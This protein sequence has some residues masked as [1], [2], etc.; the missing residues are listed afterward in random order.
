MPGTMVSRPRTQ[1]HAITGADSDPGERP[2]E[3]DQQALVEHRAPHLPARRAERAQDADLARAL[4]HRHRQRV[5]HAE[6]ADDHG[7]R[8]DR[9]E[10]VE[11]LGDLVVDLAA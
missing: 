1:N 7:D 5:D 2:G 3:R 10:E 4:D 11:L 9:V 6:Q 8:H